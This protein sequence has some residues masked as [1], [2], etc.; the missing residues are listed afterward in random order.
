[1]QN[2]KFRELSLY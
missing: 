1:M 2:L